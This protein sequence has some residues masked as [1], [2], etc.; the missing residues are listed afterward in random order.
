[1]KRG[2]LGIDDR[3]PEEEMQ[4]VGYSWLVCCLLGSIKISLCWGFWTQLRIVL[5]THETHGT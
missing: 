1:M 3:E 5:S 2:Q 4:E